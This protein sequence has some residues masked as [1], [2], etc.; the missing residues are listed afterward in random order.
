VL[1]NS[2]SSVLPGSRQ[3]ANTQG[4]AVASGDIKREN[5][6]NLNNPSNNHQVVSRQSLTQPGQKSSILMNS[7][8][9]AMNIKEGKQMKQ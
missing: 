7:G 3:I 2:V 1:S 4:A 8:G 6:G 5:T 9:L